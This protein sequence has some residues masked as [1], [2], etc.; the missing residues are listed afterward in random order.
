MAITSQA[1]PQNKASD[2]VWHEPLCIIF[3]FVRGKAAVRAARTNYHRW[4]SRA[5]GAACTRHLLKIM[6][7][8]RLMVICFCLNAWQPIMPKRNRNLENLQDSHFL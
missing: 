7:E 2:S 4:E 8:G 5:V 6:L 1:I 3:S